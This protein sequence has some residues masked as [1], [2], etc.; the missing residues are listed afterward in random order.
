M[1]ALFRQREPGKGP[2]AVCALCIRETG[3]QPARLEQGHGESGW[4]EV[5]VSRRLD[6][7][8]HAGRAAVR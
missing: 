2:E 8:G 6:Y 4:H 5:C 7:G 3:W 1:G